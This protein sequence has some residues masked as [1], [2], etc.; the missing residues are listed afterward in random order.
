MPTPRIGHM[1]QPAGVPDRSLRPPRYEFLGLLGLVALYS[2]TAVE[3]SAEWYDTVNV[4]GPAVLIV[5]LVASAYRMLRLSSPNIWAALFWFRVSTAVYFGF[6]QIA[7]YLMNDELYLEVMQYHETT[8][9][10]LV[11]LNLLVAFGMLCVV[12]GASA[13]GASL[14]PLVLTATDRQTISRQVFRLGVTF[15]LIGGF[16][17]YVIIIP[18]SMGWV[19]GVQP[20]AISSF[21]ALLEAGLYLLT[22]WVLYTK[23]WR[24]MAL[25]GALVALEVSTGLLLM[26]KYEVILP[27]VVFLLAILTQRVTLM[28]LAIVG[29]TILVMFSFLVPVVS[30]ARNALWR[31]GF[32]ENG[33]VGI[34]ERVRLL[35]EA[36]S[37][38]PTWAQNEERQDGLTRLSYANI[39]G[40]LVARYDSGQ[41]GDFLREICWSFLSH[42]SCGPRSRS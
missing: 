14:R 15:I 34:G 26:S 12:S 4:V 31:L 28:R 41:P 10:Q 39:G 22:L 25:A 11:K 2:F 19:T 24:A 8:P 23:D 13:L 6:G 29:L 30:G 32:S 37:P 42:V 20:N 1:A 16:L 40:F 5:L 36:V 7:P 3:L 33:N 9:E 17:K 38:D 21:G 35:S 27:V 18:Y